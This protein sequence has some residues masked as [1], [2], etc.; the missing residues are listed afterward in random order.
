M[1]ISLSAARAEVRHGRRQ[2]KRTK[3]LMANALA[4]SAEL[5]E[6]DV[7][8]SDA[9]AHRAFVFVEEAARVSP[10][11]YTPGEATGVLKAFQ[12]ALD[13]YTDPPPVGDPGA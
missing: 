6:E 5:I 1:A 3:Y 10:W 8:A 12:L 13:R 4:L 9:I 2:P 7:I 11:E